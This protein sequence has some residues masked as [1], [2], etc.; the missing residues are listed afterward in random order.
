MSGSTKED[1]CPICNKPVDDDDKY[2]AQS[3]AIQTLIASSKEKKLRIHRQKQFEGNLS[4]I[5]LHSSCYKTFTKK[6][7]STKGFSVAGDDVREPKTNNFGKSLRSCTQSSKQLF[8]FKN[9]CFYCGEDASDQLID[10]E[11]L[12]GLKQR[13][14]IYKCSSGNSVADNIKSFAKNRDDDLGEKVL[15]R[16]SNVNDLKSIE[17]RYHE[18]RRLDFKEIK[19]SSSKRISDQK[20]LPPIV[21]FINNIYWKIVM[22]VNFLSQKF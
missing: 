14:I 1:T 11:K 20:S 9:L 18:T 16:L 5:I 2:P 8:D 17:A 10:K 4:T 19:K 13:S 15:L 6:K 22:N 7:E 3:A 12:K 21:E